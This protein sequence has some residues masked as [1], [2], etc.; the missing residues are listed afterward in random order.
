[1]DIYSI[2]LDPLNN[3]MT[4]LEPLR[5]H[6]MLIVN[7]ASKCGYTPQFESL[8]SLYQQY[9]DQG[10]TVLGFPSNQFKNQDPGTNKDI[11]EFCTLHYGVSFPMFQKTRVNGPNRHPLYEHLIKHAP[12]PYND[13]IAWNFEKFL[14]TKEGDVYKRYPSNVD[15]LTIKEDIDRLL[16]VNYDR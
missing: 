16:E 1:M 9:K 4:S 13:N 6:V 3:T 2:P 5:G 7:T 14:I 15:P 12:F 10:F 11:L 8:E